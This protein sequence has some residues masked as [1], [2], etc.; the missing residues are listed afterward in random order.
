MSIAWKSEGN[1]SFSHQFD[2]SCWLVEEWP[3]KLEFL[4]NP[5]SPISSIMNWGQWRESKCISC[6]H[7]FFW[8][9]IWKTTLKTLIVVRWC[10]FFFLVPTAKWVCANVN[11]I[12]FFLLLSIVQRILEEKKKKST[13]FRLFGSVSMQM[14]HVCI[15]TYSIEFHATL[16]VI[17]TYLFS[18]FLYSFSSVVLLFVTCSLVQL[19]FLIDSDW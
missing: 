9:L 12:F 15:V 10:C 17:L 19:I 2:I 3:K 8:K 16:C 11:Y 6:I 1:T 7:I 13:K 14:T 4:K 5:K 18:F